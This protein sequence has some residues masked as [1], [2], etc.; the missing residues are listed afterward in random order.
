ME[1]DP[2]VVAAVGQDHAGLA[3]DDNAATDLGR[4]VVMP[5]N[6][7]AVVV[8]HGFLHAGAALAG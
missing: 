6:V 4:H 2:D 3:I 1:D 5:A 7:V 8:A